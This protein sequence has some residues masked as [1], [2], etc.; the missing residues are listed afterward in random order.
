MPEIIKDL[1]RVLYHKV[2]KWC[3]YSFYNAGFISLKKSH[4]YFGIS[5]RSW[6]SVQCQS[7]LSSFPSD[8]HSWSLTSIN[9]LSPNMHIQILQTDLYTFS[10]RMCWENLVKE[11]RHFLL[12]DQFINSHNLISWQSMDMVRRKLM[13]VTNYLTNYKPWVRIPLKSQNILRVYLQL[14]KLQLLLRP[15]YLHLKKLYFRSLH[16][17][18]VTRI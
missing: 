10:Q 13:L 8:E 2:C 6:T 18:H 17:L 11:P 7:N 14:F 16:H 4:I 5:L 12:G 3:C 9:P 15:S 1:C